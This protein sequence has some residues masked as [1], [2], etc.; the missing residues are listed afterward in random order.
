MVYRTDGDDELV[1][2]TALLER[3]MSDSQIRQARERGELVS[4]LPGLYRPA[5]PARCRDPASRYRATLT[6]VIPHLA[7]EPVVSHV[8]AAI[9]HGLPFCH[10]EV[11]PLHV[12]RPDAAKSRRGAAV[13]LHKASLNAAEVVD[14]GGL[15]VTSAERT[16]VDCALSMPFDH[17]VV[18]ADA[19]LRRGLVTGQSL[20]EQ[21]S[22]L[23]R[24]PQS[25]QAAAVL[26]FADPRSAGPGESFS[27]V[28]LHKWGFPVPALAVPVS[29]LHGRALGEFAFAFPDGRVLGQ[30]VDRLPDDRVGPERETALSEAGWRL[31]HWSWPDL[32]SPEP[33]AQR[34]RSVLAGPPPGRC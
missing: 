34:L 9:V 10:S 19:A 32:R 20:Q 15:A 31:V 27:R 30:F 23:R 12:T 22:R 5:D 7:G 4:V 18:L 21:L 33:W 1:S 25:R 8:S 3:G 24:V 16:V 29:A 2:R 13:R 26:A 28:L 6:V 11:P 14:L 17:A